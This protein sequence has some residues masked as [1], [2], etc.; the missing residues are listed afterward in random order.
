MATGIAFLAFLLA[1]QL[2]IQA[3][4]SGFIGV[5]MAVDGLVANTKLIG[6]LGGAP[7]R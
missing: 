6:N 2:L 3:T 1:A 7:L 4:T 5:D